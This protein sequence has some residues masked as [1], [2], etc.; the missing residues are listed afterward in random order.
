MDKNSTL[1]Q[2]M[3]MRMNG[4]INGCKADEYGKET[5]PKVRPLGGIR[6]MP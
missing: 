6:D 2:F 4:I 1:Y 3:D 5:P